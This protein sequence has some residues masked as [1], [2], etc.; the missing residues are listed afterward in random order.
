MTSGD[1]RRIVNRASLS[2]AKVGGVIRVEL[3]CAGAAVR[4]EGMKMGIGVLSSRMLGVLLLLALAAPAHAADPDDLLARLQ[5]LPGVDSVVAAESPI[6]DTQF[7]R[8]TFVQPVNHFKPGSG[9]FLQRATL[10]HRDASLPQRPGLAE[11][12]DGQ[13]LCWGA[14]RRRRA[15]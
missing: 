1:A 3:G 13:Q 7:F 2:A 11:R 6:P 5:A 15:D 8:I 10:L 14:S 9:T 12:H 4:Q